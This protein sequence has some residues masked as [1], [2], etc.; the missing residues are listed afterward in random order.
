M[1]IPRMRVELL[2]LLLSIAGLGFGN[3]ELHASVADST[4][5]HYQNIPRRNVFGLTAPST[6]VQTSAPPRQLPQLTLTGITTILGDKRAL[7]KARQPNAR[8]NQVTAE[9]SMILAEG[10]RAGPVEVLAIDENAGRV[11]VKNSGTV[12]TLTFE[13]NGPKPVVANTTPAFGVPLGTALPTNAAPSLPTS[14]VRMLPNQIPTQSPYSSYPAGS[15]PALSPTGGGPLPPVP[16]PKQ[17]PIDLS[18]LTPEEQAIVQHLSDQ[19]TAPSF[20]AYTTPASQVGEPGTVS[21]PSGAKPP[22][23]VPAATP[24]ATVPPNAPGTWRTLVPQ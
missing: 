21:P 16:I 19:T 12:E 23:T 1:Y 3:A 9:D 7:L 10:Q 14:A 5:A 20:P 18:N 2:G 17:Q 11:K 22:D 6:L 15:L 13:A 8:T 24:P 4:P